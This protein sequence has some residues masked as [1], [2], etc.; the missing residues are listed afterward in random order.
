MLSSVFFPPLWTASETG[1]DYHPI[2]F[3]QDRLME[4]LF[5]VCIQLLNKTW[6]E[7]RA[8]QEDFDKV[9]YHVS[10]QW[11]GNKLTTRCF[12]LLKS[13]YMEKGGIGSESDISCNKQIRP[14]P[15]EHLILM[16]NYII[17]IFNSPSSIYARNI[18]HR[19]GLH[20]SKVSIFSSTIQFLCRESCVNIVCREWL[21]NQS[22]VKNAQWK[23]R[24][25]GPKAELFGFM[26]NQWEHS[27]FLLCKDN[28]CIKVS[29][30]NSGFANR[31]FMLLYVTTMSCI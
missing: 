27:S 11:T 4:E 7:M 28:T 18:F 26:V 29:C 2:F 9:K 13:G 6:K 23:I 3:G 21:N 12:L 10:W 22:L 8:T 20:H 14:L 30:I 24:E 1:S 19:V 17:S 5:C 25:W 16:N 31:I 15:K